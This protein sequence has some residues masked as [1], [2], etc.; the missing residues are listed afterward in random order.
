MILLTFFLLVLPLALAYPQTGTPV[1]NPPATSVNIETGFTG[2]A[3]CSNT[4]DTILKRNINDAVRLADAGLDEIHDELSPDTYPQR[5]HQ[6]VDFSKQAAIDFFGPESK[7]APEQSRIFGMCPI[8]FRSVVLRVSHC[9]GLCNV[10]CGT[11]ETA[12]RVPID[13]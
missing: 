1:I 6:Q 8:Y 7:N 10:R 12:S 11:E 2:F 13:S 5:N 3:G 4:Q 9:N